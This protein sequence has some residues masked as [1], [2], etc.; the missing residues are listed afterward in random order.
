MYVQF[1]EKQKAKKYIFLHNYLFQECPKYGIL[2]TT[3]EIRISLSTCCVPELCLTF[4]A[5]VIRALTRG[6]Q[7]SFVSPALS[8]TEKIRTA[9]STC[10]VP[11]FNPSKEQRV[12]NITCCT[13]FAFIKFEALFYTQHL[14]F[15]TLHI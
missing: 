1:E 8:A 13:E 6:S 10:C 9:L 12:E 2:Y 5:N 15:R 14:F 11:E 7:I 3:E 4:C